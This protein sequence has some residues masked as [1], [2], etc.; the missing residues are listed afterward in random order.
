MR[1]CICHDSRFDMPGAYRVKWSCGCDYETIVIANSQAEALGIWIK[2]MTEES[3]S[4][5]PDND[6]PDSIE[7]ISKHASVITPAYVEAIVEQAKRC[8]AGNCGVCAKR[9]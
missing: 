3:D 7:R 8:D 6:E 2:F 5:D 4:F 9:G 1:D